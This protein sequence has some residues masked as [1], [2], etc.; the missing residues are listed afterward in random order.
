MRSARGV[1]LIV[2]V[3]A[4]IL[5]ATV[6]VWALR[7]SHRFPTEAAIYVTCVLALLLAN[8]AYVWRQPPD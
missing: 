8:A 4:A 5:I 2:D 6:F 3:G 7:G 1:L